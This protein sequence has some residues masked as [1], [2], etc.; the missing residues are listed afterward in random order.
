[1]KRED[2]AGE[3]L[4]LLLREP[5]GQQALRKL[6]SSLGTEGSEFRVQIRK[7]LESGCVPDITL[8]QQG[9]KVAFLELK[10]WASLTKHQLS[11]GYYTRPLFFIVP[12]ERMAW[13]KKHVAG[14]K[15][16]HPVAAHSWN[17]LLD[18]IKQSVR[19]GTTKRGRLFLG[20]LEHLKEFC[21]VIEQEQ[22]T[23]FTSEELGT[24]PLESE[25]HLIWLTET[26]SAAAVKAGILA[27][28]GRPF[29]SRDTFFHYGQ[30]VR[31][32]D[33]GAW[34]GYWPEAWKA[35]PEDGPLWVQFTKEN[36]QRLE[37]S[38][39][40]QDG[41][42]VQN[43][44]L[45]FPLLRPEPFPA[46]SQQEECDRVVASLAKLADRLRGISVAVSDLPHD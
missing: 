6:L 18:L 46:G 11:G 39:Q 38:G 32:G 1:M 10:F 26:V 9:A 15:S 41:V 21:Q 22:F 24:F 33:F 3:V 17:D 27:D 16:Q 8:L 44:S 29:A 4:V 43:D 34:L 30:Y 42:V 28:A 7:E 35:S 37:A 12:E 23:P 5:A 2:L 25:R 36:L 45:S 13:F 14:V 20:A 40:F 19:D 31:I